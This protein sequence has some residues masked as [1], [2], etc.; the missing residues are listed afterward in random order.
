[1]RALSEFSEVFAQIPPY[2]RKELVRLVVQR[3]EL[4]PDSMN[5]A[6][7]G[8]VAP[9]GPVCEGGAVSRIGISVCLPSLD[10]VRT[11]C[12]SS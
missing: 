3:V 6:L 10:D 9:L 8:R 12:S 5:M 11:S 2:Q 7:Y 4:A 1:M